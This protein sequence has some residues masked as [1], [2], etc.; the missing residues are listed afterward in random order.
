MHVIFVPMLSL[1]GHP[2]A[3]EV[4]LSVCNWLISC[5]AKLEQRACIRSLQEH[6]PRQ[7]RSPCPIHLSGEAGRYWAFPE[8]EDRC[9]RAILVPS[10]YEEDRISWPVSSPTRITTV[11]AQNC[12]KPSR[13]GKF[14]QLAALL[15]SLIFVWY[16]GD[17]CHEA[18]ERPAI[19]ESFRHLGA[20][21]VELGGL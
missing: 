2:G 1:L 6:H 5:I 8:H 20:L 4:S 13:G 15:L 14:L 17:G 21:R 7:Q 12:R 3:A 11:C 16:I 9:M 10:G 18:S 19:K